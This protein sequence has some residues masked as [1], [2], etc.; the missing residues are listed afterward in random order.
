MADKKP[1]ATHMDAADPTSRAISGSSAPSALVG[2]VACLGMIALFALGLPSVLSEGLGSNPTIIFG[3]FFVPGLL[4]FPAMLFD[5]YRGRIARTLTLRSGE[6]A[7]LLPYRRMS[8][9]GMY[10]VVTCN[11]AMFLLAPIAAGQIPSDA[12][13]RGVIIFYVFAL[14]A[15]FFAVLGIG[16]LGNRLIRKRSELGIGLGR[17]G[18]YHWSWLG[19]CFYPW[20]NVEKVLPS[21]QY[22]VPLIRLVPGRRWAPYGDLEENRF[23]ERQWYLSK[24]ARFGARGFSV[25]PAALLQILHFYHRHPE[26]REELGTDAAL[27][28]I[29]SADFAD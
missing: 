19:G 6:S 4:L 24:L 3:L 10:A 26:L 27:E 2:G 11:T 28:R 8:R 18:I 7:T 9:V 16:F 23:S 12:A 13:G 15:P 21:V 1:D 5:R 20:K 29:R 25:D 22:G 17:N 14:V